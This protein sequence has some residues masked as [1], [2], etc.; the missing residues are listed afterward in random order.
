MDLGYEAVTVCV[1]TQRLTEG[2]C[3]RML[4]LEFR[5]SLPEGVVPCGERGEYHS[6][7][8]DGPAIRR[9]V[10]FTLGEVHLHEPFAFQELFPGG[11]PCHIPN[12]N[13]GVE[14]LG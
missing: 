1:D 2:H 8:F 3:G 12:R 13:R 7:V 10:P 5:D 9:P 11:L 4:T 6:F 14:H